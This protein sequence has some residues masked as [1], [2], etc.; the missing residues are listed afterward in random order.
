MSQMPTPAV[1]RVLPAEGSEAFTGQVGQNLVAKAQIDAQKMIAKAQIDAEAKMNAARLQVQERQGQLDREAQASN[2]SNLNQARAQEQEKELAARQQ[3]MEKQRAFEDKW[4]QREEQQAIRAQQIARDLQMAEIDAELAEAQN[5][6]D[7]ATK[8]SEQAKALRAEQSRI[9][10]DIISNTLAMQTSQE[11]SALKVS[12]MLSMSTSFTSQS[13]TLM[14]KGADAG[15]QAF[16]DLTA[17][18][19]GRKKG[20]AGR[21]VDR[22]KQNPLLG[23]GVIGEIADNLA[24]TGMEAIE[25]DSPTAA[26]NSIFVDPQATAMELGRRIVASGLP[27]QGDAEQVATELGELIAAGIQARTGGP[28]AGAAK[29]AFADKWNSLSASVGTE[30]LLGVV[31]NLSNRAVGQ[32]EAT[33]VMVA[34]KTAVGQNE[35]KATL[36][37]LRGLRGLVRT[38]ESLNLVTDP[39]QRHKTLE[40]GVAQLVGAYATLASEEQLRSKL[41]EM[42]FS[43]KQGAELLKVLLEA[44][45]EDL[46]A[47]G[48]ADIIEQRRRALDATEQAVEFDLQSAVLRGSA[49]SSRKGSET[50]RR[51]LGAIDFDL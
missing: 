32:S 37:T 43:P 36:E 16:R 7:T 38:A 41:K 26:R 18:D 10:A 1:N 46:K 39:Q 42:G 29:Q 51:A 33:D 40:Q 2:Y 28:D 27:V 17:D 48:A 19:A 20:F 24:Q 9:E 22:Y 6:T 12:E 11:K 14:Q 31:S 50:R 5:D 21:V 8:L 47:K 30:A 3:E 44:R 25:Q 34:E 4:R 15:G 45:G 49:E 23:G 35:K 13:A